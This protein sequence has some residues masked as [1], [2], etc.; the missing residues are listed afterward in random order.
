MFPSF[1]GQ[2][3][4]GNFEVD[5]L[6]RDVEKLIYLVFAAYRI[7]KPRIIFSFLFGVSKF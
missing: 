6:A 2:S 4:T 3:G 7:I 5:P 1:R